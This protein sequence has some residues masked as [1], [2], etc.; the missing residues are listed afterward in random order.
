MNKKGDAVSVANA[1]GNLPGVKIIETHIEFFWQIVLSSAYLG[2]T[3]TA[4]IRTQRN[5]SY[6][7]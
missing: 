4:R 1:K 3:H 7:F 6:I 5:L 2:T